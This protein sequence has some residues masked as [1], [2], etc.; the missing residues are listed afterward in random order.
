MKQCWVNNS[1]SNTGMVDFWK[2]HAL[3][4]KEVDKSKLKNKIRKKINSEITDFGHK[5]LIY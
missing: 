3:I 5:I 1:Q 2:N 4:N